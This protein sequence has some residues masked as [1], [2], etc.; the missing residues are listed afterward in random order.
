MDELVGEVRRYWA[1]QGLQPKDVDLSGL[2]GDVCGRLPPTYEAFLRQAGLPDREDDQGFLFWQPSELRS[3]AAL[4]VHQDVPDRAALESLW[5]FADYLQESWCYGLWLSDDRLGEVS[6]VTG[7]G[8]PRPS[9]GTF[10]EFLS[11]YLVDDPILYST[12]FGTSGNI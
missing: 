1:E 5:V 10:P 11:A 4:L 12:N 8:D 6:L 7:V 3:A 2:P 9:I